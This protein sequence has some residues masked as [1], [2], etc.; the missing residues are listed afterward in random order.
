MLV[1]S[2]KLIFWFALISVSLALL[3]GVLPRVAPLMALLGLAALITTGADAWAGL[4]K[5]D[6]LTISAPPLTRLSADRPAD[7]AVTI[8]R[9]EDSACV[10][11]LALDFP[12]Y[13]DTPPHGVTTRLPAG[14]QSAVQA[15]PCTVPRRGAFTLRVCGV[16]HLSPLG[17]W[18]ARKRHSIAADV[19]VYPNLLRDH[20]GAAGLFLKHNTPGLQAVRQVGRGREFEQLREYSPGDSFDEV[21]WK[22]TARRGHPI[23]KMFQVEKTQQVYVV[24]DASRLSA[25]RHGRPGGNDASPP[26][27]ALDKAVTAALLTGL[28]AEKQGD[29]FGL[30]TF[31]DRVLNFIP[32]RSG[33]NHYG[34]CRDI[35]YHLEPDPVTPDFGEMA[36]AL[37]LNIHRRAL[38]MILT[39]LDN[40]VLS[41]DFQ[42][43]IRLINR[44]HLILVNMI[45]PAAV[46]PLFSGP[47]PRSLH[48]AY[49]RLSGHLRWSELHTTARELKHIGVDFS[50]LENEK[51]CM[52]TVR[53]YLDVKRR[54][55]V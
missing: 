42:D 19:R 26:E 21:D 5:R 29:H 44:Q 51:M 32:A 55:R 16:E 17:L 35:L 27:S 31:S 30:M 25:R 18:H 8:T 22:A 54:Q 7:V 14:S 43:A 12:A 49:E 6:G 11:R 48:E 13:V 4:R 10:I 46:T 23:T 37:R 1:P 20:A 3:G 50:L 38:I 9:K 15:I 24:V 36:T 28:A 53:Q 2:N 52:D 41:E 45:R 40:P 39:S 34:V 47:S 33:K